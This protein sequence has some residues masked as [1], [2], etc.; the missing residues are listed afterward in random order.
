[1][2][3][4]ADTVFT[5]GMIIP[6]DGNARPI[7]FQWNPKIVNI[8]KLILWQHIRVAGR[9]HGFQQYG[10]GEPRIYSIT[11][12]LSRSNNSDRFVKSNV[13]DIMELTK[14]QD[15]GGTVKR[16]PICMLIMGD[17]IQLMCIV[18]QVRVNNLEFFDPLGLNSTYAVVTVE[19]EEYIRES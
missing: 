6:I 13:D 10:C 7:T 16:P 12:E 3:G 17:Y 11:F 18:R 2:Y 19:F 9:E 15:V 4:D 14:P 1:M 8:Q 5:R